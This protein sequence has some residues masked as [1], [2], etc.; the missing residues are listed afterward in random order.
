MSNKEYKYFRAKLASKD[1]QEIFVDTQRE[2]AEALL[3]WEEEGPQKFK[4]EVKVILKGGAN[5][6][7]VL[8]GNSLYVYK[9]EEVVPLTAAE[10]VRQLQDIFHDDTLDIYSFSDQV[11]D[12][13]EK[14]LKIDLNGS[15]L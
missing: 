3:N 14:S 13:V 7:Q 4:D 1:L 6:V 11:S 8:Y 2:Q 5:Q 15:K 9:R 10:V 12:L